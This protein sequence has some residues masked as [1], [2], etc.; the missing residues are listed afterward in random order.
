MK[1][2]A[3]GGQR[4]LGVLPEPE[5]HTGLGGTTWHHDEGTRRRKPVSPF[6]W[7]Y[8]PQWNVELDH[9]GEPKETDQTGIETE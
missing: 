4:M 2:D 7:Y 6:C 1:S 9:N 3:A 5:S 8:R